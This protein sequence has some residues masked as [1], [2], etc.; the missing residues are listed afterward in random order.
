MVELLRA[1]IAAAGERLEF[2]LIIGDAG[3]GH[4]AIV[5]EDHEGVVRRDAGEGRVLDFGAILFEELLLRFT[6]RIDV[7]AHSGIS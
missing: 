1:R 7:V 4:P 5:D 6:F 3:G 2:A